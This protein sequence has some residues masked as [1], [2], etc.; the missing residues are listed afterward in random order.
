MVHSF[1]KHHFNFDTIE[2]DNLSCDL[3]HEDHVRVRSLHRR[4]PPPTPSAIWGHFHIVSQSE[5][6]LILR[7]KVGDVH[8]FFFAHDRSVI[9]RSWDHGGRDLVIP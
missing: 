3:T 5:N 6:W 1:D 7:A 4:S 9:T 8:L 2:F